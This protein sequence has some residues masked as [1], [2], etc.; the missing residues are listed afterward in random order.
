[1]VFLAKLSFPTT[2]LLD[3]TEA[4]KV[5]K[6]FANGTLPYERSHV[7]SLNEED[8]TFGLL[9]SKSPRAPLQAWFGATLDSDRREYISD[10][11]GKVIKTDDQ[12][13]FHSNYWLYMNVKRPSFG[14]IYTQREIEDESYTDGWCHRL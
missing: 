2:A 12:K 6:M 1:M 14:S 8:L 13:Y 4:V 10:V 5:C 3:K 11:T 7:N 9:P